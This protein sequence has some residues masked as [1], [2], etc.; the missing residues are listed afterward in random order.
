MIYLCLK[1]IGTDQLFSLCH[2]RLHGC[3]LGHTL[4]TAPGIPLCLSFEVQH[5]WP[6]WRGEKWQLYLRSKIEFSFRAQLKKSTFKNI[7]KSSDV[8]KCDL[9][10][11]TWWMTHITLSQLISMILV[12]E[13]SHKLLKRGLI[14]N[15][16]LNISHY[17]WFWQLI[18]H[19]QTNPL[20]PACYSASNLISLKVK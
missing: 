20:I 9:E 18:I 17:Q 3:L 1:A 12:P 19:I 10:M 11:V 8:C 13:L 2:V 15:A 14:S 5:A 4:L 16:W 6:L 7:F